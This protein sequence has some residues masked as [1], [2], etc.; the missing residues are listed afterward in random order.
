MRNITSTTKKWL[1]RF[2]S[3]EPDSFQFE[4]VYL[5]V[6]KFNEKP[7]WPAYDACL[8][9]RTVQWEKRILPERAQHHCP[10]EYVRRSPRTC[11]SM[12][13]VCILRVDILLDGVSART[14]KQLHWFQSG[15]DIMFYLCIDNFIIT[16]RMEQQFITIHNRFRFFFLFFFSSPFRNSRVFWNFYCSVDIEYYHCRMPQQIHLDSRDC[17]LFGHIDSWWPV[18]S[19]NFIQNDILQQLVFFFFFNFQCVGNGSLHYLVVEPTENWL[20]PT[21]HRIRHSYFLVLLIGRPIYLFDI[22]VQFI[23]LI[24]SLPFQR[25]TLTKWNIIRTF[26]FSISSTTLVNEWTRPQVPKSEDIVTRIYV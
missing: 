2:D 8:I 25:C 21:V 1:F 3:T 14:L 6:I 20:F 19:L 13:G 10:M 7:V 15:L 17:H 24:V 11:T 23:L 18:R 26:D 16:Y 12:C 9:R 22:I 4:A 5:L